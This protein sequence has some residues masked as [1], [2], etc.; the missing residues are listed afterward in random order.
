[1]KRLLTVATLALAVEAIAIPGDLNLDGAVD[2]D[3]WCLTCCWRRELPG[4]KP[5]MGT[6]GVPIFTAAA[7]DP[8]WLSLSRMPLVFSIVS[9]HSPQRR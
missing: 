1:M 3:G 2:F 9:R 5:E 7:P 4:R 6:N 8:K